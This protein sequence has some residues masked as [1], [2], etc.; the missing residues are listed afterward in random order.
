MIITIN[1]PNNNMKPR[2][3][4]L[5]NLGFRPFFLAGAC[6]AIYAMLSWALYFNGYI[7]LASG[8]ITPN[9]WHAH[10]MLYGY[11][12]AIV[13]GFMLT[14]VKNWTGINTLQRWP[15]LGLFSLWGMARVMNGW[16][17]L[18]LDIGAVFDVLFNLCAIIAVI[19]PIVHAKKWMQLGLV[20]KLFVLAVGNA[21][22]YAQTYNLLGEGAMYSE[23]I[24]LVMMVSLMLVIG[25]R[26]IPMFI[27]RGV[28]VPVELKQFLWADKLILVLMVAWLVSELTSQRYLNSAWLCGLI[29]VVNGVRLSGWYTKAVWRF[30]LLWSLYLS[31]CLINLG[32]L[33]LALQHLQWVPVTWSL[34]LFTIGGIGLM[35]LSMMSRVSL[36][37]TGRN[38]KA[39]P[40]SVKYACSAIVLSLVCRV[41]LPWVDM[42]QYLAWLTLATLCWIAA[43]LWFLKDYWQVL[44]KPRVDG[45][46][47]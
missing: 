4:A 14:A 34:H 15:L 46:E 43:F 25:R 17:L 8:S 10:E 28:D 5:F 20:F 44:T 27:E 37:H 18:Q 19:I 32:F 30:P 11:G 3:F 39:P 40:G 29:C 16:P 45:L 6:F 1:A 41:G 24:A 31:M 21:L 26:V 12:M 22:F 13:V 36:G 9:Q 23:T 7:S 2:G 33:G 47:G 35:T 42:S 38:I